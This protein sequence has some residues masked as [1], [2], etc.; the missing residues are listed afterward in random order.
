[1]KLQSQ[2]LLRLSTLLAGLLFAALLPA[3][4]TLNFLTSAPTPGANDIYNFTGS[5]NDSGNVND[6]GAYSDGAANDAFTYLSSFD[7]PSQGQTFTTGPG[8]GKVTA[9]W[10]RHAGYTTDTVDTY[11]QFA[12]GTPVTSRITDP[13]QVNT[14]GFALDAET[15]TITGSEYLNPGTGFSLTGSGMWL[16]LGLTNGP[17][18]SANTTYG[19]DVTLLSSGTSY[20]E[21]LGTDSDAYSGG[22]AYR[23]S[24]VGA[25]D[26][27]L[28][29]LS[30]DR[31]FL[32]ELNGHFVPPTPLNSGVLNF[33]PNAPTPTVNDQYNLTGAGTDSGNCNDGNFYADGAA[34]DGFTYVAN[35]RTDQ[36]QLFTTGSNPGGYHIRAIWVRHCGYTANTDLTWF[37]F[38]ASGNPTFIFR[39]T[40]PSKAGTNGFALDEETVQVTGTEINNPDPVGVQNSANGDGVW[41]RFGFSS[42][43]TNILLQPNTQY[44]FDIMG[45]SGDFFEMLGTTNDVYS[46]GQAYNGTASSGTPD[47]VTNLLH[48]DRVFL[49]EYAED[50]PPWAPSY[51]PP[52]ITN[53]P[54]NV[55]I[56]QGANA[57]F[58]PGVGGTSPFNYQWYF[59]TNTLLSGQTN[60][61]LTIPAVN[62]NNSVIGGYSVVITNFFGGITSRV[63]RLS[64]ELPMITTNLNFS[65]TAAGAILDAS[66]NATPFNV[67]LPGTGADYSGSDDPNL[68]Y[69]PANGVLNI[70]STTYD[71]NGESGLDEAEAIG[72]TLDCIGFN[73]T[74]DFTVTGYF[75][76]YNATANYDQIGLFAASAATNILRGGAIYNS[77]FTAE[78]GSYGV[79][80]Q[81]GAE[82]G[83]NT[84]TPPTNEMAVL[85][86]RTAGVWSMNVDGLNVTPNASLTY[87]NG[88]MNGPT[89]LVV[90][91]FAE[92]NALD[93]PTSQVN[94][95]SASLFIPKLGV[96]A[97]GGN[98]TFTWN[99][100]G[101]G[102]QSNPNLSNPNGWTAV[103]GASASA[104]VI[105]IPTTGSMFYRIV[106]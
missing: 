62:T 66:G 85:I 93:T 28:N 11:W 74:Q 22:T 19:F 77:D 63:A 70:T 78:P 42:F 56:P 89:N 57:V 18:L 2:K 15:Y 101:A 76:N 14:A 8:G 47:N 20:F 23:G 102:L 65:A 79:G 104:Y 45:A 12:A 94:G 9:I 40:D 99:V 17:T 71:F 1:M 83:I 26:N 46:G 58:A 39:L 53:Q 60:A 97:G 59:N 88:P 16:R 54:A 90:G 61:T 30:G 67:R 50:Y 21:A 55:W 69:D 25:V 91:V 32:V 72:I 81:N 27:S 86:G 51:F 52:T 10:I 87:L 29:P 48:G 82:L 98:L 43:G 80:D 37:D 103:P 38:A 24:T 44:G 96:V 64:V 6:G 49:V 4:T 100:V 41:M 73:G 106:P 3:Q 5:A 36:G 7:K 33:Q 13:S 105:P 84:A 35:G 34:N 68:F 75:T 31:V 92:N 95:F